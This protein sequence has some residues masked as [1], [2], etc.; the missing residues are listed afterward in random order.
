LAVAYLLPFVVYLSIYLFISYY[1]W[2]LHR[3]KTC[4]PVGQK[5]QLLGDKFSS[6]GD[7]YVT[8]LQC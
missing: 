4:H 5:S 6:L 2:T 7:I 3:G 1:Y 8:Q